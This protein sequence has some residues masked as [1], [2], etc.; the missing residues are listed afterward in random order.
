[1]EKRFRTSFSGT[2]NRRPPF[3]APELT[4][5][6]GDNI[7]AG[8]AY[9]LASLKKLDWDAI[10]PIAHAFSANVVASMFNHVDEDFRYGPD[11]NQFLP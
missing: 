5:G 10:V 1:M 4:F 11:K 3:L 2:C 9:A 6:A 8:T 7:N